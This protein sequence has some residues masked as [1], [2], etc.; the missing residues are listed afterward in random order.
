MFHGQLYFTVFSFLVSPLS[1]GPWFHCLWSFGSECLVLRACTFSPGKL[2]AVYEALAHA[3]PNLTVYK[4]EEIPERWH[5]KYND[6]IQPIIAVADEGW[7]ILQNKSDE[8]L[9]EY[10]IVF[11]P[12]LHRFLL[13]W[14]LWII[15]QFTC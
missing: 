2:D 9:C 11:L 12:I 13:T 14:R 15:Q 3:H 5:Y 8:F 1:R 10:V 7:Y 4:K 6:R